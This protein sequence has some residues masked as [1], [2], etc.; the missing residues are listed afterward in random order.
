[1]IYLGIILLAIVVYLLCGFRVVHP[2]EVA[3]VG[4]FGEI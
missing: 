3:V 4:M 2:N 1:M